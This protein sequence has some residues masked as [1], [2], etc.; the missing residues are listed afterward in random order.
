MCG[1]V[2]MPAD[3]KF[4][5]PGFALA[6]RTSWATSVTGRFGFTVSTSGEEPTTLTVA[7]SLRS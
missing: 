3:A 5:L 4:S 1:V 6:Y 7:R 2:P